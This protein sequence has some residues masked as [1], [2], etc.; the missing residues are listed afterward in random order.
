[1]KVQLLLA[2]FIICFGNSKGQAML[3]K[4]SLVTQICLVFRND[5]AIEPDSLKVLRIL[6]GQLGPYLQRISQDSAVTLIKFFYLRLQRECSVFREMVLRLEGLPPGK[7]NWIDVDIEP[8]S[9]IS[10]TDYNDFFNLKHLKYIE[11]TGDTVIVN[12]TDS[13]WEDI[14]LDGTFSKLS[15][16]KLN[17]SEFSITFIESNNLLRKYF[18]K[19][20]DK[21][22][23]KI[24]KRETKY[25]SMF[26][27]AI[28]TDFK[29]LFKLYY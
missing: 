3:D 21:Y 2:F 18:S 25:Y 5:Q 6:G 10:K 26:V 7:R 29:Q 19:P 1:M 11:P 14:F 4:D 16:A 17:Q 9:Q 20:G 27:H 8:E 24:L 13:T 15:L 23:Y 12:I 28:G 22:R